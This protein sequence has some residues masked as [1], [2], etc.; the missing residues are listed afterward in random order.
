MARNSAGFDQR[1]KGE[2]TPAEQGS[3]Q[4]FLNKRDNMLAIGKAKERHFKVLKQAYLAE[5]KRILAKAMEYHQ[6]A[7]EAKKATAPD[8]DQSFLAKWKRLQEEKRV[9]EEDKKEVKEEDENE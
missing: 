6:K 2:T 5:E 8:D 1:Y 3:E 7:E 4:F 9:K